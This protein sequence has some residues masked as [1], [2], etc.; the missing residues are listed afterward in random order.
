MRWLYGASPH[1]ARRAA[2]RSPSATFALKATFCHAPS[3]S[4]RRA[5]IRQ[6]DATRVKLMP[7]DPAPIEAARRNAS[8]GA[9]AAFP[10]QLARVLLCFVRSLQVLSL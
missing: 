9:G 3:A 6:F 1:L 7:S 2:P 10:S 4:D 5:T 8:V